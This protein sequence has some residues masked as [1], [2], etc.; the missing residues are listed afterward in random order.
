ML[1]KVLSVLAR[2]DF[3]YVE[4]DSN[5][6]IAGI[7]ICIIIAVILIIDRVTGGDITNKK[8]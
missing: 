6:G 3:R 5:T 7:I 2:T 8:Q 4:Q 1:F